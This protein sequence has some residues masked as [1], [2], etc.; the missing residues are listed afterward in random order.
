M[1]RG[2]M[3]WD[4]AELPRATLELR[5]ARLQDAMASAGLDAVIVYTNLVRSAGVAWLTGFSP[6]W[7]DGVLMVPR[8][9]EPVFATTLSNRVASW[10]R[11]VKPIGDLVHHPRPGAALAQRLSGA[12][13]VGVVELDDLPSG[14]Y[15]DLADGL[16]EAA[17]IDASAVFGAARVPDAA[18]RA[19]LTR[20]DEIA[21]T[22][23]GYVPAVRPLSVGDA[24]GP[25]E[26]A[27][28]RAGAEE[29]YLAIAPDAAANMTFLRVSG[30]APCGD[31]FAVRA[32]VAYK[33]AW[34]RR[35]RSFG[36]DFS[37]V[38]AWF[39]SL[40][41][42]YQD[43]TTLRDAM[44]DLGGARLV[45][46]FAE[47]PLGTRPL[48]VVDTAPVILTVQL[49]LAGIPWCGAGLVARSN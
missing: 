6:Y 1:R 43:R 42:R 28:R 4:E 32:S 46:C 40:L 20:A 35:I 31:V 2:L 27:A 26:E 48:A 11:S 34:V 14:I 22:A 44:R 15:D 9:G 47:A 30:S 7:A 49:D 12:H 8:S 21:W 13:K 24:I 5:V 33:G 17:I 41:E 29:A 38:E 19:L 25:V 23:L 39:A 16:A 10:V 37:N 18:E 3:K 45:K 36:A